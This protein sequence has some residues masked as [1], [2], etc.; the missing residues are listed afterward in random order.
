[1]P[2]YE[3]KCVD[4]DKSW[5]KIQSVELER[6]LPHTSCCPKCQ[7][8]CESISFGGSGTLLKGKHMNKYLEGFPDQTSKLNDE[9]ERDAAEM[10]KEYDQYTREQT[11]GIE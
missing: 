6:G 10:E 3:F 2:T 7:K 4:C 1:M 8:T 9:A 5:S 11:E